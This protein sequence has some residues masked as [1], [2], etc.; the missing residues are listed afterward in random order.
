MP[1]IWQ[2]GQMYYSLRWGRQPSAGF[3]FP[4]ISREIENFNIWTTLIWKKRNLQYLC[5][6]K[7]S[8][9]LRQNMVMPRGSRSSVTGSPALLILCGKIKKNT[10]GLAPSGS[11]G[12]FAVQG[13]LILRSCALL[14]NQYSEKYI[15]K[16][17]YHWGE[18]IE[19]FIIFSCKNAKNTWRVWG[20]PHNST[21]FSYSSSFEPQRRFCFEEQETFPSGL[22][23]QRNIS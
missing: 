3:V 11:Q 8:W 4:A 5:S 23:P 18:N 12:N 22:P 9:Q 13:S 10:M 15:F 19:L 2:V 16:V 7:I 1:R 6:T 20:C 21:I 17:K 14:F